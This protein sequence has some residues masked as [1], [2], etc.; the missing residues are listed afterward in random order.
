M[1][2]ST[3]RPGHL[4]QDLHLE[5]VAPASEFCSIKFVQSEQPESTLTVP[6]FAADEQ[7]S[8]PTTNGVR[9]IAGAGHKG[10]IETART[11]DQIGSGFFSH[12]DEDRDIPGEM[13]AIAVQGDYVS[14]IVV[15]R[16]SNA[17]AQSGGLAA[18]SWQLQTSGTGSPGNVRRSVAGSI[19]DYHNLYNIWRGLLHNSCDVRG[20]VECGN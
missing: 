20:F 7:R 5:F 18:I 10:T 4:N 15:A 16:E 19:V 8:Q 6:Y 9:E 11:D 13:L 12:A 1:Y 17:G 2:N 14:K 3:A